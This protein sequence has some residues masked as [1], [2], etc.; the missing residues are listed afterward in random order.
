MVSH[1]CKWKTCDRLK[2]VINFFHLWLLRCNHQIFLILNNDKSVQTTLI[3][4]LGVKWSSSIFE[5]GEEWTKRSL[6]DY[7]RDCIHHGEKDF[8][9]WQ[10]WGVVYRWK[11]AAG[12]KTRHAAVKKNVFCL[13]KY[14][15]TRWLNFRV[16]C[17]FNQW[18]LS[19]YIRKES[20]LNSIYSNSVLRDTT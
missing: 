3:V 20:N 8:Y 5:G 12:E 15:N 1:P 7:L 4:A 10:N 6:Q 11:F 18:N 2:F 16:F 13:M 19:I 9:M 14:F 17:P